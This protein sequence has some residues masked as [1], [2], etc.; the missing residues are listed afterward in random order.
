M[1][2]KTIRNMRALLLLIC[3]TGVLT[4]FTQCSTQDL[5][6]TP[7]PEATPNPE[8][9]P[10][11]EPDPE[12][13]PDPDD[14]NHNP[15]VETWEMTYDNCRTVVY[16]FHYPLNLGLYDP[17][18]SLSEEYKNLT[19]TVTIRWVGDE[20]S[21]KGIFPQYPETWIKGSV[22]GDK[23]HFD[24]MQQLEW[25]GGEQIYFHSGV[26]SYRMQNANRSITAQMTFKPLIIQQDTDYDFTISKDRE[27]IE[28]SNHYYS[29]L[30][31]DAFWLS[32]SKEPEMEFHTTWQNG[33]VECI[34][35]P[36]PSTCMMNM[37][38]RKI[39]TVHEETGPAGAD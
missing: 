29:P 39:G 18:L 28:S 14:P 37:V 20:F 38:F 10:E 33:K 13:N 5:E 31:G 17:R 36:D 6:P 9:E 22:K 15:I 12:P 3:L 30:A 19:H 11:P 21:I 1:I 23:V 2:D 24:S 7:V 27:T 34:P 16:G 4:T 8:P 32:K 26:V 25:T 35:F